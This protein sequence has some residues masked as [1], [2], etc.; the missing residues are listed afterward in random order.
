MIL[1]HSL[2][3]Q[4][5]IMSLFCHWL[6]ASHIMSLGLGFLRFS[7]FSCLLLLNILISITFC[8]LSS[9]LVLS[10][11]Q[12]IPYMGIKPDQFNRV[13]VPWPFK[14]HLT[15]SLLYLSNGRISITVDLGCL[16][17][18]GKISWTFRVHFHV[19]QP[20]N[21]SLIGFCQ[22]FIAANKLL[23]ANSI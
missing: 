18:N 10:F 15:I 16:L 21:C 6:N 20:K 1:T 5:S 4:E 7:L 19:I 22:K 9:F 12:I 23:I 2:N 17:S 14:M 11:F 8:F 13:L 3:S